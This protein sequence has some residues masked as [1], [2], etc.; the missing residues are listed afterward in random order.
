MPGTA[1]R[2]RLRDDKKLLPQH[3]LGSRAQGDSARRERT[4]LQ[5]VVNFPTLLHEFHEEV[6]RLPLL[7]ARYR[8][9]RDAL[10]ATDV[11]DV[12]TD[13][14]KI[15]YI[16]I[17]AGLEK[18]LDELVGDDTAYLDWA[19]KPDAASLNDARVQLRHALDLHHRLVDMEKFRRE[20]EEAL[21]G[22]MSEEN[23]RRLVE[24]G[25]AVSEAPG[26]EVQV[27]GFGQND[28]SQRDR[29]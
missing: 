12:A 14:S 4:I 20:A 1:R 6:E 19:A 27:P 15:N 10:L 9:L 16:L 22:D 7:S 29:G 23:L 2:R 24:S 5:T 28:G 26:I 3:G 13:K 21:A 11:G 17:Q 18:L 8:A 25:R